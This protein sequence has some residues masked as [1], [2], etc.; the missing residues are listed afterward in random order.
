MSTDLFYYY[1]FSLLHFQQQGYA[2]RKHREPCRKIVSFIVSLRVDKYH[3]RRV[4]WDSLLNDSF[5]DQYRLLKYEAF[6][7]VSSQFNIFYYFISL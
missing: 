1:S 2:R 4:V 6:R 3:E 7:A 5:S